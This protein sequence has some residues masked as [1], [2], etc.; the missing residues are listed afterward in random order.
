M[1]DTILLAV[2]ACGCAVLL[3]VLRSS[4][5]ARRFAL[6][7]LSGFATLG[8]VNLTA[9]ATGVGLSVN[10]WTLLTA[11]MLGLPGVTGLLFLRVMW[12]M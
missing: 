12:G 8:V 5:S 1:R 9:L 10:L 7:S 6:G 2:A 11:A 4:H 3:L